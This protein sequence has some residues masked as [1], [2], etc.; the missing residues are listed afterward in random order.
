MKYQQGGY[1][2]E[3]NNHPV[4]FL[5]WLRKPKMIDF[6]VSPASEWIH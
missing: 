6:T 4:S 5:N 2:R 3:Q 1:I